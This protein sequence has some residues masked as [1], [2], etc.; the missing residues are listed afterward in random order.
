MLDE[1]HACT[2]P[3]FNKESTSRRQK[4]KKSATGA[5]EKSVTIASAADYLQK[6]GNFLAGLLP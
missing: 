3:C 4:N 2:M 6:A 1:I 5:I